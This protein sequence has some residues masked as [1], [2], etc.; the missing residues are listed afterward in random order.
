[1]K[2]FCSVWRT[3]R[4]SFTC[5]L[6]MVPSRYFREHL[7]SLHHEQR[8]LELNF[9]EV[10]CFTKETQVVFNYVQALISAKVLILISSFLVNV[11]KQIKQLFLN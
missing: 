4:L 5:L 3:V 10:F 7:E 6:W 2:Y 9:W 11:A 1:M 8:V